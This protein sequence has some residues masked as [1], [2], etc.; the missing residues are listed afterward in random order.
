MGNKNKDVT[1]GPEMNEPVERVQSE[2]LKWT[3][4]DQA[5]Q[6]SMYDGAGLGRNFLN[7]RK[8]QEVE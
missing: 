6:N 5:S 1:Y 2:E 3:N 4:A 8:Y 7:K